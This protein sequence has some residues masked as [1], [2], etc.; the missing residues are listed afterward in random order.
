MKH[1]SPRHE[2]IN[3]DPQNP[4]NL[5]LCVCNPSIVGTMGPETGSVNKIFI[6]VNKRHLP[7]VKVE[8]KGNA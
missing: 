2:G 1:L 7:Q 8:G 3:M 6:A 4:L 5:V